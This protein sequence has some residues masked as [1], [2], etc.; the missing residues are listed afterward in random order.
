MKIEKYAVNV[1][2]LECFHVAKVPGGYMDGDKRTEK[3][4]KKTVTV[5]LFT[6][7]LDRVCFVLQCESATS[8]SGGGKRGA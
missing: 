4:K 6:L 7:K 5:K 1:P 2:T 8:I 3:K